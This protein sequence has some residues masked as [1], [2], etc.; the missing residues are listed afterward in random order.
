MTDEEPPLSDVLAPER[1]A[2]GP[3]F[4]TPWHARVFGLVVALHEEGEDFDWTEFQQR[5]IAEVADTDQSMSPADVLEEAYYEQWLA[6][7]ERLLV[8]SGRLAPGETE[9]RAAEFAADER[10]AEEFVE[11][12]RDH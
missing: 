3:V 11:G 9:D 10:T 8:D 4:E 12:E 2:D 1:G 5:L 6:A 7:F